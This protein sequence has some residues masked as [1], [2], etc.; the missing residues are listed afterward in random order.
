MGVPKRILKKS[1]EA[2]TA[3]VSAF[4]TEYFSK[5]SIASLAIIDLNSWVRLSA[6]KTVF[7]TFTVSTKP[8]SRIPIVILWES[9]STKIL[10]YSNFLGF[11]NSFFLKYIFILSLLSLSQASLSPF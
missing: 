3:K 10:Q 4:A 5:S 1:L 9:I 7:L 8:S 11:T 6:F 2:L